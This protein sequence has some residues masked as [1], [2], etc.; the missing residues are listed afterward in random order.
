MTALEKQVCFDVGNAVGIVPD[1]PQLSLSIAPNI[2]FQD[3]EKLQAN[4]VHQA[5]SRA[6]RRKVGN[7]ALYQIEVQLNL[8]FREGTAT[9]MRN[10]TNHTNAELEL[11]QALGGGAARILAVA[12]PLHPESNY[13]NW[14]GKTII[15]VQGEV[16]AQF[17]VRN[18]S[19]SIFPLDNKIQRISVQKESGGPTVSLIRQA[20]AHPTA[21]TTKRAAT[22]QQIR[23]VLLENLFEEMDGEPA[24][25]PAKTKDGQEVEWRDVPAT[26]GRRAIAQTSLDQLPDVADG[27]GLS[28]DVRSILGDAK[29]TEKLE[30]TSAM[31]F[32]ALESLVE[33][34]LLVIELSEDGNDYHLYSAVRYIDPLPEPHQ[35][36]MDVDRRD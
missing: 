18:L 15:I 32:G 36:A 5:I 30:I 4:A 29:M 25:L 13:V 12:F 23:H 1:S 31:L 9:E 8:K 21:S 16:M 24:T 10:R 6:S 33:D 3:R 14:F 20:D 11:V 17:L 28:R 7:G 19:T 22:K 35:D 26:E 2:N 27:D 34:R